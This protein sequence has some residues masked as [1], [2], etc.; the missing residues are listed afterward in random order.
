MSYPVRGMVAARR[1]S[2]YLQVAMMRTM[3]EH[4]SMNLPMGWRELTED[5][6]YSDPMEGERKTFGRPGGPSVMF[7]SLL[8]LDPDRPPVLTCDDALTLARG[9]GRARGL[10]GPL[11]DGAEH[12]E[13]GVLAAAEYRLAGDYVAVYYLSNGEATLHASFITSWKT[14]H[15]ER[16]A[17]DAMI[18][19]LVIG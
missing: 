8:P 6:T 17:R 11:S 9:W 3:F 13:D 15:D 18:S 19:S 16:A 10:A 12:R 7:V 2:C 1:A 5:S 4:F 14:R